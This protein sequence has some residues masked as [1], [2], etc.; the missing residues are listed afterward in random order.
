MRYDGSVDGNFAAK[1][2]VSLFLEEGTPKEDLISQ[3]EALAQKLKDAIKQVSDKENFTVEVSVAK[4]ID[5]YEAEEAICP[6]SVL[7]EYTEDVP[8]IAGSKS[9]DWYQPDDPNEAELPDAVGDMQEIIE[10]AMKEIGKEP[11]EFEI[12]DHEDLGDT[13]DDI[14]DKVA[15]D[16]RCPDVPD[17]EP[18]YDD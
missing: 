11:E 16:I 12:N 9:H 4:D 14:Y 5:D 17:Y 2:N 15:D 10:K 8:Y 6:V 1:F 7:M 18:D 13:E 3:G